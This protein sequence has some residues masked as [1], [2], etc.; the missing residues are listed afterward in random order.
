M[1]CYVFINTA[2]DRALDVVATLRGLRGIVAVEALAGEYDV[3]AACEGP[4][5]SSIGKLVVEQIQRA[6]GVAR[7]TTCLSVLDRASRLVGSIGLAT[8]FPGN[9]AG[10]AESTS[11][12][13]PAPS[14]SAAAPFEP[15][16]ATDTELATLINR[17]F[18]LAESGQKEQ[19]IPIYDEVIRRARGV[20]GLERIYAKA[21]SNQGQMLSSLGRAREAVEVLNEFR[22]RFD[23][24]RDPIYD[25]DL[26]QVLLALG[27]SL[28]HL[29]RPAE[30]LKAL[31][32]L[33]QSFGRS[34]DPMIRVAVAWA[35][36]NRAVA[37]GMLGR[38]AD[39]RAGLQQV[40]NI[41]S[42]SS[43]PRILEVVASTRSRLG[44]MH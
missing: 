19:C 40:L 37:L 29:Q 30:S 8:A 21:L 9:R 16:S 23:S 7:T 22:A 3:I 33:L 41:Y 12:Q 44:L 6:P 2:Q 36:A 13:G 42:S 34:T 5:V 1:Q 4:D 10:V 18:W 26:V 38:V 35:L 24:T 25:Q 39:C 17:A 20:R 11:S 43:D 14:H 31:N 15:T 28:G 27:I 32:E